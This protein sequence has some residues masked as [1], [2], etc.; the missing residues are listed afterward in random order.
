MKKLFLIS[1]FLLTIN[2]TNISGTKNTKGIAITAKALIEYVAEKL[3]IEID[4]DAEYIEEFE[5]T[6]LNI[7]PSVLSLS[8][9]KLWGFLRCML[10]LKAYSLVKIN[11]KNFV[12]VKKNNKKIEK[13]PIGKHLGDNIFKL[14]VFFKQKTF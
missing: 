12:I 3:N 9:K 10:N 8:P 6:N 13:E 14:P 1:A 5:Y 4:F 7:S 2:A 11:D